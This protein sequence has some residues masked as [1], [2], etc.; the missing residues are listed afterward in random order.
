LPQGSKPAALVDHLRLINHLDE[1]KTYTL[2]QVRAENA[3][4]FRTHRAIGKNWVYRGNTFD[5]TIEMKARVKGFQF[6]PVQTGGPQCLASV[7]L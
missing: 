4:R 3:Q 1:T 6:L 5:Q 2:E 7:H